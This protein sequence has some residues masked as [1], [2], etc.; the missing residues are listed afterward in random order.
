MKPIYAWLLFLWAP[1]AFGY[2]QSSYF[3]LAL[4]NE[5]I[6]AIYYLGSST[7]GQWSDFQIHQF[8]WITYTTNGEEVMAFNIDSK[9]KYKYLKSKAPVEQY[10]SQGGKDFMYVRSN[11]SDELVHVSGEEK[12][13]IKAANKIIEYAYINAT[14]IAIIEENRDGNKKAILY[15]TESNQQ[16]ALSI[17]PGDRIQRISDNEVAY[18]DIFSRSFRY[19]KTYDRLSNQSSIVTQV[20]NTVRDFSANSTGDYFIAYDGVIKKFKK[21]RDTSWQTFLALEKYGITNPSNVWA[22]GNDL[23]IIEHEK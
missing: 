10:A 5:N 7:N 12:T 2:S 8:D 4:D 15:T 17:N 6:E 19:I 13:T 1:T 22:L 20:P 11:D 21:G 9:E 16:K 18:I 23:M 3:A 14:Q